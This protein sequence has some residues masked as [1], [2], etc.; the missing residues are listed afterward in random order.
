MP[1]YISD[2][3]KTAICEAKAAKSV[4]SVAQKYNIPYTILLEHVKGKFAEHVG[5]GRPTTLTHNEEKKLF[6][7]AKCYKKWALG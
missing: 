1:K 7:A 4:R 6:I 5:P 3:L 2:L